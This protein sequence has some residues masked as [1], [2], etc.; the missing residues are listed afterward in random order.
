MS[1]FFFNHKREHYLF[2]HLN[3]KSKQFLCLVSIPLCAINKSTHTMRYTLMNAYNCLIKLFLRL[4]YQIILTWQLLIVIH[5]WTII[6]CTC[7]AELTLWRRLD[8]YYK[9]VGLEKLWGPFNVFE[10]RRQKQI[11]SMAKS[12]SNR[13]NVTRSFSKC[14]FSCD[15]NLLQKCTQ[16]RRTIDSKWNDIHYHNCKIWTHFKVKLQDHKYEGCLYNKSDFLKLCKHFNL[17]LLFQT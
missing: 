4:N 13:V 3:L 2:P 10:R 17:L 16:N 1:F 6:S 9:S 8:W 15:K 14:Y 7:K 5:S 12:L 11:K